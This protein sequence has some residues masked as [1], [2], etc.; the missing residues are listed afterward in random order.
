MKRIVVTRMLE[1][2]GISVAKTESFGNVDVCSPKLDSPHERDAL[3]NSCRQFGETPDDILAMRLTTIIETGDIYQA[4]ILAQERFEE[5][6]NIRATQTAGSSRIRLMQAGYFRRIGGNIT[7]REPARN[8]PQGLQ[9]RVSSSFFEPMDFG[10]WLYVHKR[11]ELAQRLIRSFHWS[12]RAKLEPSRQLR[13]LFRWFAM[14]TI[15]TIRADDDVTPRVLWALGIPNGKGLML[16]SP[17][18]I[19]RIRAH[20]RYDYWKRA[21]EQTARDMKAF[22]NETVHNGF[23]AQDKTSEQ[24]RS[25]GRVSWLACNGVQAHTEMA[26]RVGVTSAEEL[27]EY[28]PVLLDTDDYADIAVANIIYALENNNRYFED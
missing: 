16:M 6:A 21:L 10:K 26:L 19:A 24:L 5:I 4:D 13:V 20:A 25:F 3:H 11:S 14:E 22:R 23:R 9:F 15:W 1:P 12:H 8:S 27:L 17:A 2:R 18:R 7:C 28:L